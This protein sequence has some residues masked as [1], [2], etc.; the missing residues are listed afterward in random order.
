MHIF[1][2]EQLDVVPGIEHPS[3]IVKR[4]VGS[5][6]VAEPAALLVAGAHT[7]L[8]SKQRYTEPAAGRSMT[9]AVAR[10]PFP[11]RKTEGAN[12]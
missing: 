7:L 9:L 3:E 10:I 1:P 5:R 11:K 12:E 6:G 2:A 8:V 4:Y